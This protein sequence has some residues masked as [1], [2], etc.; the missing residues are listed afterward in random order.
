M[1][2]CVATRN[3][4]VRGRAGRVTNTSG[5]KTPA[6]GAGLAHAARRMTSAGDSRLQPIPTIVRDSFDRTLACRVWI[7]DG[8]R[9]VDADPRA[10]A[11]LGAGRTL[12][13]F[14]AT[15]ELRTPFAVISVAQVPFDVRL[16]EWC[17]H[18]AALQG[19]QDV[20][21]RRATPG[22]VELTHLPAAELARVARVDVA[23][24]DVAQAD[25]ARVAVQDGARVVQLSTF[26]AP[27]RALHPELVQRFDLLSAGP[28]RAER[29][30]LHRVGTSPTLVFELPSSWRVQGDASADAIAVLAWI[31]HEARPTRAYVLLRLAGPDTPIDAAA[32][33]RRVAAIVWRAGGV[34]LTALAADPSGPG[35]AATAQMFDGRKH[36]VRT[37]LVEVG[38]RALDVVMIAVAS[39]EHRID[40]LRAR[41][42][43]G[44]VAADAR[45]ES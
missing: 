38:G 29:W 33:V 3:V 25:V 17:I 44:E 15:S 45:V 34:L 16:D 26:A 9:R 22:R 13:A 24:I 23:R 7:P 32:H 19:V 27:Q 30:Q 11:R 28:L 39:P 42:V 10:L 41:R 8:W 37:R 5:S 1:Y 36:D 18:C 21:I 31:E 43:L 4:D 35:W 14:S 2:L 20:R 40:W 6:G 12:A